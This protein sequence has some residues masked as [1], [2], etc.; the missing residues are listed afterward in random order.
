MGQVLPSYR[1]TTLWPSPVKCLLMSKHTM[2]ILRE[3]VCQCSPALRSFTHTSVAGMWLYRMTIS[4]WKWSSK[5]LSMWPTHLQCMLLHMQKYNYTIQYNPSKEMVLADHLSHFPSH[6]KSLPIPI[7]QNIQ[8]IQLSTAKLHAIQDFIEC[9]LAYS[10]LYNLTLRGWLDHWQQVPRIARYFWG[11]QDELSIEAGLLLEG[12]CICIPPELLDH[13]LAHLQTVHQGMKKMQAQA[14]EAVY[15]PS[16]NTDIVDYVCWCTICTKHKASPPVQPMLSRDIPHSPWQEIIADY[17]TH[18]GKEYFLICDLF[19]KYPFLSKVTSKLAHSV[20]APAW[21]HLL[22]MVPLHVWW[23]LPIP[24]VPL[25]WPCQLVPHFPQSYVF[26]EHQ[27]R[28]I[29]T[30]PNTTQD[31]G[32]SLEE[33]LLGLHSTPIG[34]NMPL[35]WEILHSRTSSTLASLQPLLTW[36]EPATSCWQRSRAKSS[37][38]ITPTMLKSRNTS[39]QARRY[40]SSP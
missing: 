19:S 18:K 28:T 29:K 38:S 14:R 30:A 39:A 40:C 10:T 31:A 21:T 9:D 22:I 11:T 16:I 6:K 37:T 32:K 12:S 26:I 20:A 4:H 34:P 13:T 25:H 5:S 3:C 15:G 1:S 7:A 2:Q 23:V 33:L 17:L 8:H 27:V 24:V 35:P 36:N